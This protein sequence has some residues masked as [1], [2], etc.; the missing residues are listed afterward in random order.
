MVS[1]PRFSLSTKSTK[2]TK[3]D[4]FFGLIL[5]RFVLFVPF[6]DKIPNRLT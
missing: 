5:Y 2:D 1:H 4:M 3:G 6:V